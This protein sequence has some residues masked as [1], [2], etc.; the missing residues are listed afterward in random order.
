VAV[1]WRCGGPSEYDG[2]SG[3]GVELEARRGASL[4]ILQVILISELNEEARTY[5]KIR[6]S[7]DSSLGFALSGFAR[8]DKSV[9]H[10]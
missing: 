3:P 8:I 7:T 6:T 4:S 5:P 1:R 2:G 9:E 10:R